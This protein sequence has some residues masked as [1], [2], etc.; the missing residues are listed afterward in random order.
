MARNNLLN[1]REYRGWPHAAA[2]VAK[3]LWFYTFT[4]PR[5]GAASGSALDAW[6]AGL[7]GDFTGH[8]RFLR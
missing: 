7:R 3:T 2:F 5:P 8:R 1:L 4:R 6:R